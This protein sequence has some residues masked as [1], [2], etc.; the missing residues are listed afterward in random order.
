MTNHNTNDC[1]KAPQDSAST[2]DFRTNSN[3]SRKCYYCTRPG[4]F[5]RDYHIKK[6]ALELRKVSNTNANDKIINTTSSD[7]TTANASLA[8]AATV[9]AAAANAASSSWIADTG[10]SHHMCKDRYEF[11]TFKRLPML[12]PI[13][14]GNDSVTMAF[15][16]G[17]VNIANSGYMPT[18]SLHPLF[19]ALF[20]P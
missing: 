19:T 1:Y 10:A 11:K 14:L 5:E 2:S 12:L 18:P 15:Y 4:H 7:T 3:E 6:A 9:T 16:H 20:S 17:I 13:K 8:T